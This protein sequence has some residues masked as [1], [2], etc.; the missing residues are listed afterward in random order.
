[1]ALSEKAIRVLRK[2][3]VSEAEMATMTE[4][5]AWQF[6]RETSPPKREKGF[7]VCFTGFTDAEKGELV[8]M[9]KEAGLSVVTKVTVGCALL[10]AGASAGAKKMQ[11]AT[12]RGV[13]IVSREG[14]V[15]FLLTGELPG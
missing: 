14:L 13:R 5:Q 2:R 3:G 9:A 12:E 7:E 1:M 6:V 11:E 4:A 10:C 8:A 15:D